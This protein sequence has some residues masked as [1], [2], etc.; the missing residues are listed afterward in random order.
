MRTEA[1]SCSGGGAACTYN[2]RE[3][4]GDSSRPYRRDGLRRRRVNLVFLERVGK[5]ALLIAIAGTLCAQS[6]QQGARPGWPCVPGRA[7]DPSYLEISE[8]TGGQLFLFQ[9]GEVQHAALVM[10]ANSTHPSTVLRTVGHL[11]GSR[12]FEF[13]VDSSMDSLLMLAS[14]QCRQAIAVTR[15]NGAEMTASNSAENVD[16]QGGRILRVEA[17]EPGRW[18]VRLTGTG[19]Y[20]LSVLAKTPITFG[21][22]SFLEIGGDS[23][24][25]EHSVR[26]THP[27][28]AVRQWVEA[29]LGGEV[30]TVK[31]QL[32]DATGNQVPSVE[33]PEQSE[34]GAY[35]AALMPQAAR[36]RV[37]VTALDAAGW[38]V[39]RTHPVLFHAE[40]RK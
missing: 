18:K 4:G 29:N 19:L 5:Q 12:D 15:P 1:G 8:S 39:Q 11:S 21:N 25:P 17:P 9:K 33:T 23:S 14:M 7:V 34:G 26:L 30:S 16:L 24:D 6:S 38:P 20:V 22:V 28:L 36:F 27:R 3:L 31:F 10:S 40:E 2:I 32:T 13:P 35:R 37:I